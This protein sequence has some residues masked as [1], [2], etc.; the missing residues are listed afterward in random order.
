MTKAASSAAAAAG[1]NHL[2]VGWS[3]LHVLLFSLSAVIARVMAPQIK[4]EHQ[5]LSRAAFAIL[6]L[7]VATRG[8][9]FAS[10]RSAH[11]KL[12]LLRG[13]LGFA[14]VYGAFYSFTVIPIAIAM[15]IVGATPL[16]VM[17]FGA[18]L[19]RERVSAELFLYAAV[20]AV[21]IFFITGTRSAF[22]GD[23]LVSGVLV[24]LGSSVATAFAFLTV[25]SLA[26]VVGA[27]AIVFWFGLCCLAGFLA[28]GG[29]PAEILDLS[30]SGL[31]LLAALCLFG[32]GSDLTKTK[33]Y[34]YG[35]A[36][37]VSLLAI[38][39]IGVSGLLAWAVLGEATTKAQLFWIAVMMATL[40]L[41]TYRSRPGARPR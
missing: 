41:A 37:F 30:P 32:V 23:I 8:G 20:G 21:S 19:L 17:V 15:M 4:I 25:R 31:L 22:N 33:A 10:L 1:T 36:W 39:S 2:A 29:L 13:V 27:Q 28:V 12:L 14:G 11:W 7:A 38:S 18:V 26:N 16:L 9:V 5:L 40:A 35:Q 24:A 34:Q 3:S 6:V